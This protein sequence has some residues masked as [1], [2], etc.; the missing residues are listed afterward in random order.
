MNLQKL[1]TRYKQFGGA[2]LAWQY[3]KLGALWPAV[4]VGVK[5]LVKRQSFITISIT[6]Y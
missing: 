5:C 3:A 6:T 1:I 2:K 4:I